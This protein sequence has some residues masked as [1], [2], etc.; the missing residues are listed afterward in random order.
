MNQSEQICNDNDQL[1]YVKYSYFLLHLNFSSQVI[2]FM[3]VVTAEM[4]LHRK[5]D[6]VLMKKTCC[7]PL[8]KRDS[9]HSPNF[10]DLFWTRNVNNQTFMLTWWFSSTGT[11]SHHDIKEEL[12][13]ADLMR[14]TVIENGV[15]SAARSLL[16]CWDRQK[17]QGIDSCC[18][19]PDKFH[20]SQVNLQNAAAQRMKH[21]KATA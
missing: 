2:T 10:H 1:K 13:R 6:V 4:F 3:L 21:H 8:L 15:E 12:G 19:F 16:F 11:S 9:N 17:L 18:G 7:V 20:I 5:H 14:M